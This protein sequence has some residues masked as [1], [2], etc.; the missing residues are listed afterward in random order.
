MKPEEGPPK[1]QAKTTPRAAMPK[2]APKIT[3]AT[4]GGAKKKP[5]VS[6]SPAVEPQTNGMSQAP[7]PVGPSGGNSSFLQSNN[8]VRPYPG[9][10]PGPLPQ[11]QPPGP[12][13]QPSAQPMGPNAPDAGMRRNA[14]QA[15]YARY[16]QLLGSKADDSTLQRQ[17]SSLEAHI[18][19]RS[20]TRDEYS[21]HVGNE[22]KR[23]EMSQQIYG[24]PPQGEPSHPSPG[25]A[26]P[27]G[28]RPAAPYPPQTD[29]RTAPGMN[30]PPNTL[31]YQ[32]FCA[33]MQCQ[34]MQK[35]VDIMWSQRNMIYQL[36]QEVC[37][38][39]K[40]VAPMQGGSYPPSYPPSYA[41]QRPSPYYGGDATPTTGY[42]RAPT[43][44]Q[45]PPP[46]PTTAA[47]WAKISELREA[48]SGHLRKA[49][50][51][52]S[53]AAQSTTSMQSSKAEGMKQNIQY[54]MMVLNESPTTTPQP[55]D[56]SAIT[57]IE[58]FVRE[59]IMPLIRK[60]QEV[61]QLKGSTPL[62]GQ[63]TQP[64]PAQQHRGPPPTQHPQSQHPQS[65]H[66]QSQHPQSQHPQSQHPPT[67]H[68]SSQR[69]P[70]TQP[71]PTQYQAPKPEA[72]G[73]PAKAEEPKKAAA[74]KENSEPTNSMDD[75]GD[76]PALDDLDDFDD[77]D[78]G[79]Y[80]KKRPLSDI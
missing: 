70:P 4:S 32:E 10:P 61:S 68:P 20:A 15:F 2:A 35:L 50:Q 27:M 45:T 67:H 41:P 1:K 23:I 18:F 29:Y 48:Y 3:R 31:T 14:L 36:Q 44:R 16:K 77:K 7:K 13:T 80:S 38:L 9:M 79:S 40:M 47:Y 12:S 43:P 76:L 28:Q 17:A 30:V 72:R 57:S 63:P 42:D 8:V 56:T 75:F 71:P 59:S 64:L 60:V 52:L 24:T 46:P 74:T 58:A 5:A 11:Q 66:P 22:M 62:P 34:P 6:A 39:K 69:G 78:D 26:T 73:V 55:R 25:G 54:A 49:Y 53:M 33:R 19:Q 21:A 65:Q 51:I 37:Y